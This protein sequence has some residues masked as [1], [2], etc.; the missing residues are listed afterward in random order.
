MLVGFIRLTVSPICLIKNKRHNEKE[1]SVFSKQYFQPKVAIKYAM[2]VTI[3][4]HVNFIPIWCNE[5]QTIA[6]F[7]ALI[8]RYRQIQHDNK[9]K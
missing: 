8:N 2:K 6:K 1:E 3:S 5:L 4:N 7:V 9:S